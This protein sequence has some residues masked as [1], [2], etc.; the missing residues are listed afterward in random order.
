MLTQ[1][2]LS[3]TAFMTL[4]WIGVCLAASAAKSMFAQGK[5]SFFPHNFNGSLTKKSNVLLKLSF[6][7]TLPLALKFWISASDREPSMLDVA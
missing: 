1:R 5:V 7:E 3:S 6:A 2:A 4:M